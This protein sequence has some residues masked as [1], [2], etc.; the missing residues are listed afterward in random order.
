M[1][2]DTLRQSAF[3]EIYEF[4]TSS[5]APETIIAF[6]PSEATMK[7]V[8]ELL[9]VNKERKLTSS[10]ARELDEFSDL[11]H[12]V[13]MLKIYAHARLNNRQQN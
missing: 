5:P 12:L 3:H 6:Q 8:Q 1:D 2:A 4:L 9:Q 10:E 11:E 7:R 13:R